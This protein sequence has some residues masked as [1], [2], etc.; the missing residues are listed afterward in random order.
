[1]AKPS[2][3]FRFS[4]CPST[5]SHAIV[6]TCNPLIARTAVGRIAE[7]DDIA[8]VAIFLASDA[9]SYVRGQTIIA[10]GGLT[11]G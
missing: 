5:K 8:K 10:D 3:S 2:K 4:S 9:A 7:P 11:L 6:T 1:M